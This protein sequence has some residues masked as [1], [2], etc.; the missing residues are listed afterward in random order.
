MYDK[1][2]IYKHGCPKELGRGQL[3][4]SRVR[5]ASVVRDIL[6]GVLV[7]IALFFIHFFPHTAWLAGS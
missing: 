5:G 3:L 1:H 2:Q 6:L 4:G 7:C